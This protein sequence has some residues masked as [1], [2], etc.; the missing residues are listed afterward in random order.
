MMIQNSFSGSGPWSDHELISQTCSN[1]VLINVILILRRWLKSLTFKC[2][3]I[4]LK[5]KRIMISQS[6]KNLLLTWFR[7][8]PNINLHTKDYLT[9][10][11]ITPNKQ[12]M[13]LTRI[14]N[15]VNSKRPF[16]SPLA[17]PPSKRDTYLNH[18]SGLYSSPYRYIR[19]TFVEWL[20]IYKNTK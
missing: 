11:S 17:A 20:D 19:Q 9:P 15:K 14:G 8:K 12:F 4:P 3:K 16:S 10:K 5:K 13:T 2:N 6:Q 7:S 18:C 1:N